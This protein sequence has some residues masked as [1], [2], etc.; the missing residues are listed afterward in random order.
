MPKG[1]KTLLLAAL[2]TAIPLVAGPVSP[3]LAA[4]GGLIS[5]I[6]NDPSNPYWLTEGN[7]AAAEA[8]RLGYQDRRRKREAAV[9]L[10]AHYKVEPV[11]ILR[12]VHAQQVTSSGGLAGA[13]HSLGANIMTYAGWA[14]HF[15]PVRRHAPA[16]SPPA[17]ASPRSVPPPARHSP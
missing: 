12:A 16:P 11:P 5:V 9:R 3:A 8:K 10:P 7:V 14:P 6:V 13:L 2:A 4:G 17:R 15:K 1:T